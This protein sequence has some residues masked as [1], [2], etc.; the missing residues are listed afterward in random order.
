MNHA[1]S[2]FNSRSSG[3]DFVD[4]DLSSSSGGS[5]NSLNSAFAPIPILEDRIHL[6]PMEDSKYPKLPSPHLSVP[7]LP[8][9]RRPDSGESRSRISTGTSAQRRFGY[10]QAG[11]EQHKQRKCGNG[12]ACCQ[13][14]THFTL[15]N[16]DSRVG[17]SC[18]L[19]LFTG[20]RD[21][22]P[23]QYN[24]TNKNMRNAVTTIKTF[25]T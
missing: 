16:Y 21:V 14:Y 10:A 25:Q 6:P 18:K 15:V 3:N 5:N 7:V 13:S 24:L 22:R 11:V 20:P 17:I 4:P 9:I 19:L 23:G 1:R 8:P 12:N 2:K